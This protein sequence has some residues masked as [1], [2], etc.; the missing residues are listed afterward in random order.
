MMDE[1]DTLSTNPTTDDIGRDL[2]ATLVAAAAVQRELDA[3]N[4]AIIEADG[5]STSWAARF[6]LYAN[7][8]EMLRRRAKLVDRAASLMLTLANREHDGDFEAGAGH[9]A[10]LDPA[11]L[12]R[13]V[14][15]PETP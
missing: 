10:S 15:A 2:R 3:I 11:R 1:R 9:G 14:P 8:A 5:T 13:S 4:R 6:E 7:E 12:G